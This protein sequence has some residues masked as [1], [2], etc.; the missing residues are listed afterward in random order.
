MALASG[1]AAAA[2]LA[3]PVARVGGSVPQWRWLHGGI[4]PACGP[5]GSRTSRRGSA[6]LPTELHGT[7]RSWPEV[8]V[9]T[10]ATRFIGAYDGVNR[11]R[12]TA[13]GVG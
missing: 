3:V 11:T 13:G 4:A 12:T 2:R 1:V 10:M 8:A 7:R 9:N 6:V 5:P